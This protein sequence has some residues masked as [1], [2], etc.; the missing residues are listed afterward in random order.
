M[1]IYHVDATIKRKPSSNVSDTLH[2]MGSTIARKSSTTSEAL[3]SM[4]SN[5]VSKTKSKSSI[6]P[7]ASGIIYLGI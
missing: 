3:R 7:K 4:S 1:N 6:S 5:I 2:N